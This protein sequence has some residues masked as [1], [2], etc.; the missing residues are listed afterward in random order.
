MTGF[1]VLLLFYILQPS[2]QLDSSIFLIYSEDHKQCIQAQNTGSIM[3]AKCKDI[4]SQKFRWISE[5][6]LVNIGI[7][8]CLGATSKKDMAI[9][10]MF[11]CDGT[12]ELQKWECKNDTLFGIQ[13]ESL[14]MNYGNKQ[15]KVILFKG[16]GTWSKW[17]VYGTSDD[18]CSKG[19]EDIYTLQG[20]ANGQPCVFPFKFEN[21]W[22]AGCTV[23]G[24]SDGRYWCGTTPDYDK[25]KLYGF[26]PYKYTTFNLWTADPIT[27]VNYQINANSA[28]TWYQARRSC[29]QQNSD[30]LSITE[31]YEQT[32]L[33]GLTNNL[34]IPLWIG[35]NSLN[36]NAG[37]QWTGGSPFRYLNWVPGN[38]S[39]EPGKN[40]VVLNAGKN[41]KWETRECAQKLGYICKQGNITSNSF[42]I[43]SES[44]VPITCPPTWL[45]YAGNCYALKKEAKIWKEAL[46]SCRKEEG[47]LASFHNIQELSFMSS[48]LQYGETDQIWIGLNDL[49]IQMYFEWSDGT[50][51]TYTMWRRGEPSHRNNRQEDCVAFDFKEGN[52]LDEMCEKKLEY[53]CKRKPLP[54]EP[55]QLDILDRGCKKGWKRHGFYC[56]LISK[57]A[58]SFSEANETCHNNAAFLM[59]VDD[60]YEQAYLTSLIGLRPEKYFWTG[61]S[62][63]EERGVFKWTNGEKVMFTHWN[64]EMPGRKQGCVSM[65]T[66]IRGGLWDVM[67]CAE[68]ANCVCKH[69]AEG[70]TPPPI[71]T[72]TPEPKCPSGWGTNNQI[73][74]CYKNFAEKMTWFEARDF[75]RA[76]GGDLLSINTKE[77]ETL[78]NL[79]MRQRGV[80][81]QDF[82]IG[83]IK[84]DPDEGFTWSDGSPK[85]YE[86][87]AYGE[88]NNYQG[89]ELCGELNTDPSMTWNDRHCDTSTE[90]IC[91]LRKGAALKPEPTKSPLPEH[92][93]TNDGWIIFKDTQ[94]FISK[95]LV[96]MEKAREFCKKNF[97]DLAVVSSE[98]ERKF[99][100]KYILKNEKQDNYFIG[101][102][103]GLDKGFRWMDGTPL[104]YVA[105]ASYEPN[106]ANNDENCVVMYK[107][108][109][110]W[111]DINCGYPN[112][113]I[114]ERKN[115]SINATFAPTVPAPQGGC[116]SDWLPF[117]KRCY[118]IFENE[119]AEWHS[120]RTACMELNGNLVT[121]EDNL[122][123]AFLTYHLKDFVG[124]VWI[125]LNDVNSEHK[126]LWTTGS[127]V[128][129]TNWAKGHPSGSQM[130]S[131]DDDTDCVSMKQGLV[132]DAGTW[133]EEDCD[134][135]RG[136]I[137]QKNK[138]PALPVLPTVVSTSNFLKYG[139][140]SYKLVTS[141]MKW[142]EARRYCKAEDS[143]L[144]SVLD[145]YTQSFLMIHA[146]RHSEP[147][148]IGLNSNMT[149][150]QFKW[151]D[152]W[153]LRYT[154]WAAGEP[155]KKIACVH[156]D[157][158]GQWKTSSCDENYS[159][160]CKQSDVIAPTDPPQARGKC[161]ESSGKEWIPFRSHCYLF[162]STY[163][164]NWAQ[165]S[166]ECL[167]IGSS[168]VAVED[169]YE[170]NFIWHHAEQLN[171]R[172]N[173]F[174][175][176]MYKNVAG[177]WLWLDSTAVDYVNWDEG[178]PSEH[179]DEECVEL[180]STKGTWNNLYC[181]SYRGYICKILKIVETTE[182]P[183]EAPKDERKEEAP[184]HGVAGGVVIVVILVVAGTAVAVYYVYKR[185]Q[186]K[187][188]PD[189][190]FD[191]TLYFNGE[192]APST[193]DTNV[194][195]ENIEHNE[196][197]NS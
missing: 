24:R 4:D 133:V 125:G 37:W 109:G 151:I 14:Y 108:L 33:T 16:S 69:W 177:N 53:L 139:N 103:L 63:M 195:V 46:S 132:L 80:Y 93:L 89:V 168:L 99:L 29:Q 87:W 83:L 92:E 35:L 61:L 157:T 110:F 86:S 171:D 59:T 183:V 135:E 175:I 10:T 85:S 104:D 196:H 7:K 193:S 150:S 79:I 102:L 44:D 70:V 49:K 164:R 143:E 96:P 191:N 144:A 158:D 174:W 173:T 76:I 75:C 56:Y 194:L 114:C 62:D 40:C 129:Y 60:R 91:E 128:Y 153:K 176:G 90:W 45:P 32:Y 81:Y 51:V 54:V 165:A 72:T 97:G 20:N 146:F 95:D 36:F 124:N 64:S 162:Q 78:I 126:F 136:Y 179:S 178:E 23:N 180:Y 71:P 182:K 52:W 137:C 141:K 84:I 55:G 156:M 118:K 121:V 161:P 43:P 112:A 166:L 123:Q 58:L 184:S 122:V 147:F 167:R 192:R 115:S 47:D 154:K 107:N 160:I 190:S 11:P 181:S 149:Y 138:N 15:D 130:Y 142:D 140:A 42:I 88:P 185:R 131:I 34:D 2:L 30:L 68:K 100:W 113:F 3:I 8:Q 94:Y 106:F 67:S 12:S 134:L 26:C 66:G 148:W 98:T 22:Y 169:S 189:D 172:A 163:T 65:R 38:P 111:N 73:S 57:T 119:N 101:L 170:S 197:S 152:N 13:G 6:Q 187:S 105:W 1:V 74:S 21:K 127:G 155:M 25:E 9:L 19:Y 120:A 28:L 18:L 48:Q 17:K 159:S 77:E 186:N 27:S 145:E 31:V 116:P 39:T 117:R 41:A 5:H 188:P 50:P 82:W